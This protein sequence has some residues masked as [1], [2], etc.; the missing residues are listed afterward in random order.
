MGNFYRADQKEETTIPYFQAELKDCC[1][2]L[3]KISQTR[4][5]SK[6]NKDYQEIDSSIGVEKT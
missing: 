2:E 5:P 4:S 6:K 1:P 3:G